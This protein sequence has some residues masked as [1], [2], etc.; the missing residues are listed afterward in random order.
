MVRSKKQASAELLSERVTYTVPQFCARNQ[1]SRPTYTR[2]RSQGRGPAEM[3]PGLNIIRITAEAERDW[4]Q[5]MQEPQP[6]FE[7]RAVERAVKAGDAAV[8]S[9][10]RRKAR[11]QGGR[12]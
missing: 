5:L 12:F 8:K 6:D 1:I 3:R 2:L 4:Q 9:K 11:G 7:T 10:K